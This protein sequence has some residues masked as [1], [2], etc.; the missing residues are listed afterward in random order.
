M[1]EP[2]EVT[3]DYP[4]F[5]DS[6][7]VSPLGE[8]RFPLELTTLAWMHTETLREAKRLPD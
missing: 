7:L 4:D 6:T 5:F 8:G 2:I 3:I 1:A